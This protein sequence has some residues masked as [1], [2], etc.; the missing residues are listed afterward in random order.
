MWGF[1]FHFLCWYF[2]CSWLVVSIWSIGNQAAKNRSTDFEK[3]SCQAF[4]NLLIC[5]SSQNSIIFIWNINLDGKNTVLYF[6]KTTK[7][8]QMIRKISGIINNSEILEVLF[9]CLS[10]GS[11]VRLKVQISILP[12]VARC[13][14]AGRYFQFSIF[15][16]NR[17]NDITDNIGFL[18]GLNDLT[19]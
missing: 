17:D 19:T 9:E 12:L 13:P 1:A 18:W 2:W 14:W 4:E 16:W 15:S 5:I 7:N 10:T 3:S 6:N 8:K 11:K